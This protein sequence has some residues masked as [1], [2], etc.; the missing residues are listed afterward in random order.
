MIIEIWEKHL[1]KGSKCGALL[2]NL[3]KALDLT[4]ILEK[5]ELTTSEIL[6]RF[7]NNEMSSSHDTVVK[8]YYYG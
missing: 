3:P 2:T 1:E 5:L 4:L 6:K 8:K 7:S